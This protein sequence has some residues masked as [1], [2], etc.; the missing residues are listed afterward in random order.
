MLHFSEEKINKFY[1]ESIKT[2]RENMFVQWTRDDKNLLLMLVKKQKTLHADVDFG[3]ISSN[4]PNRPVVAVQ[5]QYILSGNGVVVPRRM[6]E[7][8]FPHNHRTVVKRLTAAVE[9]EH[10][11]EL[12]NKQAYY[13]LFITLFL[14]LGCQNFIISYYLLYYYIKILS[15]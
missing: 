14:I 6:V 1:L 7:E 11:E 12:K 5:A 15:Y 13:L 2:H 8:V 3:I 10:K 9:E 4:F